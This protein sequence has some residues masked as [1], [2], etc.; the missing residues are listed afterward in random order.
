MLILVILI[1]TFFS[2]NSLPSQIK[3][4]RIISLAPSTTE[5]LF[6]LGLDEEIVGVTDFCNY[7]PRVKDKES[8]GS[9][10]QPNF[11]MILSLKPDIIFAT[12]LE[13]AIVVERLRQ[14]RLKVYVSDPSNLQELFTSI[15]KIGKLTH[16]EKEAM[17]LINQ[18]KAKID[19]IRTKIKLI[20][21]E[22]R[23]KVF[24]EIWHD[25]L[26]TTGKGSF[27]DELISLAGGINIA[28]NAPRAYSYFSA[29]QIIKRN[30]DCIIFGHRSE[31]EAID[32]IKNRLGWKE[33]K[34]VKNNCVYN[35]INPDL[36]LRPGPRLIEGLEEIHR[37]LYS[38]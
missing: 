23:P 24:I 22:K 17:I 32:T 29:E 35:D 13:Q 27:V 38:K 33:I 30:P 15:K 1:I 31:G 34:A 9:F 19:Q 3:K 6:S 2:S 12:G 25:P 26:L 18:M 5:I 8:V 7:P 11:E 36:F 10:S 28:H 37:R 21:Q 16:R 20:P 14:L 4:Q